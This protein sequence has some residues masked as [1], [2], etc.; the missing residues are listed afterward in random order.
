MIDQDFDHHKNKPAVYYREPMTDQYVA[1]DNESDEEF[2]D[3]VSSS[4]SNDIGSTKSLSSFK[5]QDVLCLLDLSL[6]LKT[7]SFTINSL[8]IF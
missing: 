1:N 6:Y 5:M 3:A 7:T 4:K 2:Y 8:L